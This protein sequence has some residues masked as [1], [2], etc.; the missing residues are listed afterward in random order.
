MDEIPEAAGLPAPPAES[1]SEAPAGIVI[2]DLAP[3]DRDAVRLL[4]ERL[5]ESDA[6]FRFCGPRP[7]R[8]DTL[9][10]MICRQDFEHH[11][12]GA[13]DDGELVGVANYVLVD[14][15]RGHSTADIALVVNEHEQRHG[16]GTMLI[17]RLG[18][19]AFERGV[20]H[21]T[22]EILADNTLMLAVI[23]EQGWS[24]ALHPDG[25]VVHFDLDLQCRE[26]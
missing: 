9:A 6:Y 12:L 20:D 15:S 19:A 24:D 21:L 18:T 8:L 10:A 25:T 13:F 26:L 11:A 16:I 1:S 23:T 22:A 17:R 4:H 3:D 7:N 5:S 2:R 14:T